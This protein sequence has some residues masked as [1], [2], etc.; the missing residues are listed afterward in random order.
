[1]CE[2]GAYN[3]G[4]PNYTVWNSFLDMTNILE[5]VNA[6]E[7]EV[8]VHISFYSILGELEHERDVTVGARSQFDVILNE[9]PGFVANSYGIVEIEFEG[10]LDGRM[11]YYRQSAAGGAYDFVYALPL[12][13]ASYGTTAVSFN[14]F[15]PSYR[16]DER[17]NL[18]ANWLTVINLDAAPQTFLIWTYDQTGTLLMRRE[19]EVAGFG[20]ADVDGGHDIAG[21][22]VVGM[23]KIV[24]RDIRVRYIAQLTRFGGN[25]PAG[26]FPSEYKFAFPLVAKHGSSEPVFVPISNRLGEFNWLEVVNIKDQEIRVGISLYSSEGVLL[27]SVDSILAPHAQVHFD[28]AAILPGQDVGYAMV[29]PNIPKSIIAQSMF[30]FRDQLSGSVTS[31]YGSQGRPI[32]GCA[33]TGSYNLFLGM[34]NWLTVANS[35]DRPLQVSVAMNGAQVDSSTVFEIP[36]RGAVTLPLHDIQVFGA[37]SDSYGLVSVQSARSDAKVFTEVLRLRKDGEG[38]VDFSVPIAVR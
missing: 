26:F 21:P 30:Y 2:G 27:E 12:E 16:A 5:L 20:R 11:T 34:E 23:H 22:S 32:A 38:L 14:T 35:S 17:E 3:I 25:A 37:P 31:L 33:Q 28:A 18:V 8:P 7:S 13:E 1:L 9:F 24:P 36:A 4:S 10:A 29:K 6:S 15:Q 19:I